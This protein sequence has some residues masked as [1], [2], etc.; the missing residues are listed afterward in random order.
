MFDSEG[1]AFSE[2]ELQIQE[3]EKERK[4]T[5]QRNGRQGKMKAKIVYPLDIAT[6]EVFA[7]IINPETKNLFHKLLDDPDVRNGL[8][9]VDQSQPCVQRFLF[10]TP[11]HRQN[12]FNKMKTLLNTADFKL[13]ECIVLE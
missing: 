12:A 4:T 6:E 13:R 7:I 10:D 2:W 11:E 3:T 8:Y 1:Y 9:C 5:I